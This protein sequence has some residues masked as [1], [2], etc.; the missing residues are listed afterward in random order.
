[1]LTDFLVELIP[2]GWLTTYSY[3]PINVSSEMWDTNVLPLF[4][5]G[6]GW[7]YLKENHVGEYWSWGMPNSAGTSTLY[8][9]DS[10]I[11]HNFTNN[12]GYGARPMCIL[13]P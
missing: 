4:S 13:A 6:N 7:R 10:N 5:T 12:T 11:Q 3:S 9:K 1:M 8:N 2:D